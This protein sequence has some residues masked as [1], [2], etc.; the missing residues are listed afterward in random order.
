MIET[1]FYLDG[2]CKYY[3]SKQILYLAAEVIKIFMIE[4]LL[5][6]TNILLNIDHLFAHN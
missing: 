1:Y 5:S 6:N 4:L 2:E 3:I